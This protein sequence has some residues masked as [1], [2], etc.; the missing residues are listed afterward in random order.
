VIYGGIFMSDIL[1]QADGI[2]DVTIIP[3]IFIDQFMPSANG[4]YVKVYIYLL[5]MFMGNNPR[6]TISSIAD[7]LENTEKDIIRA[8]NYWEKLDLLTI[9]HNKQNEIISI[10]LVDPR[11]IKSENTISSAP[12]I[13]IEEIAVSLHAS[14]KPAVRQT[15]SADRIAQLTDNDQIK[16]ALHIVEIYL[17]RPLKPMD[18]QLILYLYDELHFSA[19]LIMYLYEY[20]VSKGKK[21][22]SYIE[23]VAL[24]WASDGIDTEEKAR[25]ATTTYN[26]HFL[27]VNKAFGL[28]RAPGQIERQYITKWVEVFGFSDEIITEACNRTILRT[29]KPDF[30]YTDK[31]LD[32]WFKKDVKSHTDIMKLDEE[33]AKGNKTVESAKVTPI[34]KPS[35]N[36][37]NQFPQ[38]SYTD[39]DYAELEKKLLNKGLS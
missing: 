3:N 5:R 11:T 19:E 16:Y 25:E 22:T 36:R 38:R 2:S 14:E 15:Y 24:T 8:L 1:I 4:A 12:D 34:N 23:A 21:N 32:T 26:E 30:K 37:F 35:S 27:A 18:L 7:K 17:D 6:I 39:K 10:S 31:I 33:F 29:Q 20:C 9:T 13:E 28:N